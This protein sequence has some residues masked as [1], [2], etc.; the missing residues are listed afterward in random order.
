MKLRTIATLAL[1]GLMASTSVTYAGPK[2]VSGPGAEPAA[3]AP[4]EPR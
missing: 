1:A 3:A 2:V 4:R